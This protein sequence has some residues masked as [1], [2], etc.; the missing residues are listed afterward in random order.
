MKAARTADKS[1][2]IP[3]AYA[4]SSDAQLRRGAIAGLDQPVI[5][6][7]DFAPADQAKKMT[8]QITCNGNFRFDAS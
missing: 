8:R 4:R 6:A 1:A 2:L 3:A 5:E 7:A